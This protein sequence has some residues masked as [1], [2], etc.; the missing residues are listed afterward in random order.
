[1]KL[2]FY[3]FLLLVASF[4]GCQPENDRAL[5]E[6]LN[7]EAIEQLQKQNTQEAERLLVSAI[8]ADDTFAEP[9]AYLIQIHLQNSAF[10]KALEQCEI[11]IEKAPEEAENWVLAGILREKKGDQETAFEY[12]EKSIQWFKK[13]L[14]EN[15]K[16]D[17][18]PENHDLPMQDEVNIIFSYILLD[19]HNKA[20]ELIEDLEVRYPDNAMIRNLYDFDKQ[21]YLDS[22]FPEMNPK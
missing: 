18:E 4:T 14:E 9:H 5:A 8:Q 16:N 21:M 15:A 17:P 20:N 10:D 3:I 22:L 6:Q 19:N 12:Y 2:S 13:R 11:V 7:N 1:M